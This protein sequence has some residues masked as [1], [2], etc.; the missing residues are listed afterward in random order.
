MFGGRKGRKGSRKGRKG[1]RKNRNRKGSRR[2][3]NRRNNVMF[4]GSASGFKAMA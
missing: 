4:G 3:R 2:N 1:S